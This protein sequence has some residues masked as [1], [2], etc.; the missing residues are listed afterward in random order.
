MCGFAGIW[1]GGGQPPIAADAIAGR[2]VQ[3]IAH[4]GPDA[5][6][7][8]RST[9][10][11]VGFR[12][13]SIIDVHQG[14]QPVRSADGMVE[15][16]FNGEIYNHHE[17][18]RPLE[19]DGVRFASGSDAEIIP[20]LYRRHGDGFIHRLEGMFSIC[21]VDHGRGRIML[22][23]DR[24]GIKPLLHATVNNRFIFASEMRAL[25]ASGMIDAEIDRGSLLA[26]LDYQHVPGPWTMVD[27]VQELE[28]GT[29][30]VI[31][32]GCAGPG[33]PAARTIDPQISPWY[34]PAVTPRRAMQRGDRDRLQELL[35]ES[36]ARQT[37]ADVPVGVALSGGVDSTLLAESV[38]RV[39]QRQGDDARIVA[40]TCDG[41]GSPPDEADHARATAQRLGLEHHVIQ[42]T[43]HELTRRLPELAWISDEA[44]ADP[45]LMAATW[46]SEAAAAHV[47]VLLLGAG[48]DELFAGYPS[49][50]VGRLERAWARVPRRIRRKLSDRLARGNP[51]RR[52]RLDAMGETRRTRAAMHML[53]RGQLPREERAA[54]ADSL[55]AGPGR[56]RSPDRA[57][58][59]A[60]EAAID[61]DLVTQQLHADLVTYLPDQILTMCDRAT[62]AASI[63]GRIP[64]LDRRF[65]EAAMAIDPRD[66]IAHGE[67]KRILRSLLDPAATSALR[68]RRKQGFA[69]PAATWAAAD[70]A[71]TGQR[72]LAHP[73]SLMRSVGADTWMARRIERLRRAGAGA[74]WADRGPLF[75]AVML[76]CWSHVVLNASSSTRPTMSI[77]ELLAGAPPAS[78]RRRT[79]DS[80]AASIAGEPVTR[81]ILRSAADAA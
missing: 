40:I 38:A 46:L 24:F 65:V 14:H 9:R 64:M 66:K 28:P 32:T 25:L 75:T 27:G 57:I 61:S 12:R 15:V 26:T 48:G 5:E 80:I 44:V 51:R 30:L 76:E 72:F 77:D 56:D 31:E 45:A 35:D 47:T 54:L 16:V 74:T 58:V 6:S 20:H 53:L 70:L 78:R 67:G 22:W 2:M 13:L 43:G 41:P 49:A 50:P 7:W 79:A 73:A 37:V 62:M 10:G 52:G 3:S 11:V 33:D 42:P 19:R 34:R 68:R 71:R 18:R 55:L 69:S 59:R 8:I 36:V 17:L 29:R 21:L 4:R 39:R 81:P 63:E 60:F 23:R 1:W